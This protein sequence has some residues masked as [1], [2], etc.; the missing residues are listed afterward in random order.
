MGS[1]F[2]FGPYLFKLVEPEISPSSAKPYTIVPAKK[3]KKKKRRFVNTSGSLLLLS[4]VH[5]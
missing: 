2:P 1:A 4:F 3:K 5:E